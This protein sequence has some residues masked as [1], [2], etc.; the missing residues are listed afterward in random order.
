[1]NPNRNPNPLTLASARRRC[2]FRS[3]P[4]LFFFCR[5]QKLVMIFYVYVRVLDA[6][7]LLPLRHAPVVRRPSG[8]SDADILLQL[9]LPS[10]LLLLVVL[11]VARV[12]PVPVLVLA[13]T[14]RR[15]S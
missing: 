3:P 15:A 8:L 4:P 12:L 11:S 13:A 14:P 9:P 10:L 7:S 5:F 2:T 1:M 6:I